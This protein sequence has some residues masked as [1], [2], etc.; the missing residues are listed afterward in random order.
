LSLLNNPLA[1]QDHYRLYVIHRVP[2]LKVLDFRKI[3]PQERKEAE[4]RYG[5]S[6]VDGKTDSKTTTPSKTFVVGEGVPKSTASS[7]RGLT[8]DQKKKIMEAI[9]KANSLGEIERLEKILSSGKLPADFDSDGTGKENTNKSE[10]KIEQDS[11]VVSSSVQ[12]G[13][14]TN[15]KE[16]TTDSTTTDSS[17]KSEKETGKEKTS[18]TKKDVGTENKSSS[19]EEESRSTREG[20]AESEPLAD[21]EAEEEETDESSVRA[22]ADAQVDI[23]MGE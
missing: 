8:I 5:P 22:K 9:K 4:K 12:K 20:D 1:K 13:Q 11:N 7:K 2:S 10:N 23:E 14:E 16:V 21:Q 17:T 6:I 3:K 18:S 19:S 15:K